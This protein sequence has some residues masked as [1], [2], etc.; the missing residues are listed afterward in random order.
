MTRC[1]I[2]LLLLLS[3]PCHAMETTDLFQGWRIKQKGV[4]GE[5]VVN[6][7]IWQLSNLPEGQ[8]WGVAADQYMAI[9]LNQT[10]ILSVN[11]TQLSGIFQIKINHPANDL[12]KI[13]LR[14]DTP[15][16]YEINLAQALSTSGKV[17]AN[18]TINALGQ[19]GSVT[20]NRLQLQAT[21][22]LTQTNTVADY[23]QLLQTQ[24][25]RTGFRPDHH[26]LEH[27]AERSVFTDPQTGYTIWRLTDHPAY[28]RHDYYF[29]PAWNANGSLILFVTNRH[30]ATH[31]IMNADGSDPRPLTLSRQLPCV[32]KVYW[33]HR[34]PDL[35]FASI[36]D[37][38]QTSLYQYTLSN[39][40]L[41]LIKTFDHGRLQLQPPHP[42]DQQFLLSKGKIAITYN[43]QTD[44]LHTL[45]T[46]LARHPRFT[47]DPQ[48]TFQFTLKEKVA[49][50]TDM[51]NVNWLM[52]FDG[53]SKQ[54]LS[55]IMGGH[56]DWDPTGQF[57]I[58]SHI[59]GMH[60]WF[61]DGRKPKLI[62]NLIRTMHGSYSLSTGNWHF[63]DGFNGLNTIV[64]LNT[65]TLQTTPIA[66]HA[67]SYMKWSV[68]PHPD[69]ES[70]H[71]GP[72]CSPDE[73]KVLFNSDIMG[74]P[75][76]W[77]VVFQKPQQPTN[78]KWQNNLLTWQAPTRA[79]E[80]AGYNL[81]QLDNANHT[82][83][84]IHC[85][86]TQ[87]HL[88]N[89]DQKQTY[90]LACVEYSGLESSRVIVEA[91]G[92][93]DLQTTIPSPSKAQTKILETPGCITI[94][95]Q[96]TPDA[97]ISYYQ[98][99]RLTQADQAPTPANLVGSTTTP[100]LTDWSVQSNTQVRYA[101][102]T[103]NAHGQ[104]SK[105]TFT[106]WL[107]A[108]W[109]THPPFTQR[110]EL[111]RVLSIS[112]EMIINDRAATEEQAVK[113]TRRQQNLKV[114]FDIPTPGYYTVWIN[115]YSPSYT[116]DSIYLSTDKSPMR[117]WELRPTRNEKYQYWPITLGGMV[118]V[119]F[120]KGEH[121]IEFTPRETGMRLDC[122]ILT[123]NPIGD[124]FNRQFQKQNVK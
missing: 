120:S 111:D 9:D 90:A 21:S 75:D 99:H 42:N 72:I 30:T 105:P 119:Y 118:N 124:G 107:K 103:V 86:M 10:P 51:Q 69:I 40:K 23:A 64:A 87:T 108:S 24:K 55:G 109:P 74:Q 66:T 4:V 68:A 50:Y 57:M 14:V 17:K 45:N 96:N 2:L 18:L 56:P 19:R 113:F 78:V 114:T 3:P 92:K 117:F 70:T 52:T 25:A 36:S 1:F 88:A 116:Q 112:N 83:R 59:D 38:Q 110:I 81:Y 104:A 33:S 80:L 63:S 11:C 43:R 13:L 85:R 15:G 12:K 32:E 121:T 76:L 41:A 8:P 71:P 7:S 54:R 89:L 53:S 46:G 123:N 29:I 27:F 31:W 84:R 20:L 49:G 102:I 65:K 91:T 94:R 101:I 115:A 28:E 62:N 37:D 67:S 22:L 73:T 122:L 5:L 47:N 93:T 95:W 6:E 106:K 35:M 60:M 100:S 77:Q 16:Q 48:G 34:N 39:E 58:G 79:K 44:Q 82:W 26:V 61:A 98:V 97:D